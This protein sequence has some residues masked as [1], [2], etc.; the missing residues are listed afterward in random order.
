MGVTEPSTSS[1]QEIRVVGEGQ[2]DVQIVDYKAL[3][4]TAKDE[5]QICKEKSVSE[6]SVWDGVLLSKL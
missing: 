4:E 3:T 2:R 6:L 5:G 1:W